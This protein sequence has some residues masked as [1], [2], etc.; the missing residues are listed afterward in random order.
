VSN[1]IRKAGI[2]LTLCLI[3]SAVAA[4][5]TSPENGRE[6]VRRLFEASGLEIG[7]QF[8]DVEIL[9][10]DGKPFRTADLRGSYT[11]L[12]TGCLT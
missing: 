2:S 4:Q 5:D 7:S 9:D 3:V 6:T 12:V 11:V 1:V 8:P 10:A